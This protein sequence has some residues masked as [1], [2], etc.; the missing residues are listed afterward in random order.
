MTSHCFSFPWACK[1]VNV[2][3]TSRGMDFMTV[4]KGSL[5]PSGKVSQPGWRQLSGKSVWMPESEVPN[6]DP[7]C[8]TFMIWIHWVITITCKNFCSLIGCTGKNYISPP[9][10]LPYFDTELSTFDTSGYQICGSFSPHQAILW[11]QLGVLQFNSV[12]TLSNWR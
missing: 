7:K 11:H 8:D 4:A 5:W 3:K 1:H 12:L 10:C 2:K 6:L 9:V